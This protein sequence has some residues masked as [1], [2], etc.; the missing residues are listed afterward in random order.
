[1]G[2]K[3]LVSEYKGSP[4]NSK[5]KDVKDAVNALI[6][7]QSGVNLSA[8]DMI[9]SA[10]NRVVDLVMIGDSNQLMDGYGFDGAFNT[11]CTTLYGMWATPIYGG[12]DGQNQGGTNCS[13]GGSIGVA[14]GAPSQLD[15]FS[16]GSKRYGYL[17]TG[18]FSTGN[19]GINIQNVAGVNTNANWRFHYA[20]GTFDSGSGSFRLGIR[21]GASPFNT[22]VNGVVTST[23]TGAFTY[24]K[25]A[26]D[27]PAG[28]RNTPIEFK[29]FNN[30][31]TVITAPFLAY[32]CRCENL[33]VNT[34]MSV[35]TLYGAGGEGLYDMYAAI[36]GYTEPLLT[37]YF[38]IMRD[39]QI[40][41][42]YAL[43]QLVFYINSG[44][45]D[46]NETLFPSWG[47]LGDS[48]PDSGASYFDNLWAIKDLVE[49]LWIK[50]G[51]S[52]DELSFLFIPS[53][54]I[55]NPDNSELITYRKG[56][57]RLANDPRCSFVNIA[58]LITSTQILANGW[59]KAGP[60]TSHLTTAGYNGIVDLVFNYINTQ[61]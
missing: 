45:N 22:F 13:G 54:P 15:P 42:G 4:N 31:G 37:R 49:S 60:D 25:A 27:L 61:V 9:K 56:A 33:D 8:F 21:N 14:T 59:Y 3:K 36:F 41:K 47:Y 30:G 46:R 6:D 17:A 26:L 10:S 32:W 24:Q 55:S 34:G 23:N 43:P 18:T 48:D 29:W 51:W 57:K 44:L 53:H 11:K 38:A 40:A 28:T 5:G 12:F 35:H 20:Y 19:N 52:L 50:N 39:M 16:I 2:I 58:D 1:M 7:K